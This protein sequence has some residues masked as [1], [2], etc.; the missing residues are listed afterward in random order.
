MNQVNL[1]Q[2]LLQNQN[3]QQPSQNQVNNFLRIVLF[4][5]SVVNLH[6][7]LKIDETIA[8]KFHDLGKIPGI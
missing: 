7:G 6:S 5:T 3:Q 8:T 4:R 1:I 2:T